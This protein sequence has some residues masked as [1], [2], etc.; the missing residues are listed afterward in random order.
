MLA[1]TLLA[2]GAASVLALWVGSGVSR[3]RSS[4]FGGAPLGLTTRTLPYLRQLLSQ[5]P[6]AAPRTPPAPT[7]SRA[8]A[9]P[10]SPLG[11]HD[12]LL[13]KHERGP[14][15]QARHYGH[16]QTERHGGGARA[17]RPLPGRRCCSS[18]SPH[19]ARARTL[20]LRARQPGQKAEAGSS[21][22]QLG[23]GAGGPWA[24]RRQGG[25]WAPRGGQAE[26]GSRVLGGG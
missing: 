22:E 3:P 24:A 12:A 13:L 5:H 7:P 20:R 14:V 19:S 8:A 18:R 2:R 21:A 17:A 23:C 25:V 26:G 4:P 16:A 11:A 9:R 1:E 15:H 6:A 10:T